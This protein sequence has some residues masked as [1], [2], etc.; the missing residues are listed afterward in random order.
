M[1][2]YILYSFFFACTLPAVAQTYATQPK[3]YN[4]TSFTPK[5]AAKEFKELD[6]MTPPPFQSHPEYGQV[7]YNAQC[8]DCY[9]LV[10]RRTTSSRYFV[11]TGTNGQTFYVQSSEGLLHYPDGNGNLITIDPRLEPDPLNP[12]TYYAPHQV[13]PTKMDMNNG[14]SSIILSAFEL[15]FNNNPKII[16]ITTSGET[17]ILGNISLSSSTIGDDGA[18]TLNAWNGIDR[19]VM[20]QEGKVKTNFIL[21]GQPNLQSN[22][23]WLAF[24]DQIDLPPGYAIV[25]DTTG[26][27]TTEGYWQGGLILIN[28]STSQDLA[29]WE[30]VVIND[31]DTSLVNPSAYQVLNTGNTFYVRTLVPVPWLMSGNLTFP[32]TIDPLVSGTATWSAGVIAFTDFSGPGPGCGQ[33]LTWCQG[34]P[35]NVNFPGQATIT[36]VL[37]SYAYQNV[38]GNKPCNAG[39]RILGP[40]SEDPVAPGVIWSCGGG[41]VGICNSSL[42]VVLSSNTNQPAAWLANCLA[43][44]CAASVISFTSKNIRCVVG[45]TLCATTRYF[46]PNNSFIVTVEGQTV[47]QPAA[48]TSSAGTTICPFACTNLTATGQYGVPPYI[49][50]WSPVIGN[51]ATISVCPTSTTTY[52]CVITDACGNTSSNSVTII[53]SGCLPIGLSSFD[54]TEENDA[55]R[56]D[57]ETATEMNNDYFTIERSVDGVH[58]EKVMDVKGA[59]TSSENIIY[60]EYDK[61]PFDGVSYYRLKQTDFNGS[62]SYSRII[63]VDFR[64]RDLTI[65]P[66]PVLNNAEIGFL[67]N[68]PGQVDL[69]IYNS[70]G[71][72]V[73][74]K[75]LTCSNG[76]NSVKLDMAELGK[77]IYFVRVT[78]GASQMKV[79]FVK[80]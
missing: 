33:S 62:F 50:S 11:K 22:Q 4:F 51:T 25:Y 7:P 43:P 66:N 1:K 17:P 39:F 77:G 49:Y 10:D 41:C 24:E 21:N 59:G 60:R 61:H 65:Q 13:E 80:E 8:S 35:L 74:Y 57:W 9:E 55:V 53:T 52:T 44:S 79:R 70:V 5:P 28:T 16:H 71:Q 76:M 26:S 20:F 64:F 69:R 63:S 29:H 56:L 67:C 6:L 58:F 32:V 68:A 19:K 40:C 38:M 46:T 12:N 30:P 31:S 27:F 36:N 48:P 72:E 37:W 47:N 42:L 78:S 3:I 45:V 18:L 2:K 15:K 54:V 23:G 73:H 14:T 34:G 75:K